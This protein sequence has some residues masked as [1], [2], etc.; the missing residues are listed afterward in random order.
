MF[1]LGEVFHFRTWILMVYLWQLVSVC[2]L[3]RL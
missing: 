2:G 1:G 3:N